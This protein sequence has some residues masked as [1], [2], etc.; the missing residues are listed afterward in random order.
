MKRLSTR[1]VLT[2]ALAV[3]ISAMI[4][5]PHAAIEDEALETEVKQ[6]IDRGLKWL[7]WQQKEDGSW[8]HHPGITSLALTAFAR[9]PR[10]YREDDGPFI[11]NATSSP[12]I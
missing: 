7:R 11:R 8:E 5:Q 2:A 6:A 12:A 10:A 3:L 1:A 9:S 4:G